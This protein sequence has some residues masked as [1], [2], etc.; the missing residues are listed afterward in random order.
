MYESKPY[1]Y[2]TGRRKQSVSRVR[3]YPGSGSITING[4]DINDYFG[5]ETLKLIVR[6]PLTLTDTLGKFDVV[7]TVTGG[8]PN[9]G[10]QKIRTQ[11]GPPRTPVLQ[12]LIAL[13][14]SYKSPRHEAAGFSYAGN[15]REMHV[16][17]F[18]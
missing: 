8:G 17:N 2:G 11:S 3:L 12:T 4:R 6:Q 15:Q 10:A 9:E 14:Q 1:F 13:L 16:Q 5:L 7:C 18:Y